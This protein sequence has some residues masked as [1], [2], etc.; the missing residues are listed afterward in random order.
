MRGGERAFRLRRR[1]PWHADHAGGGKGRHVPRGIHPRTSRP[2]TNATSPLFGVDFDHYHST[3]SQE[4]RELADADLH[5]LARRRQHRPPLDP[6]VVRPGSSRCSCPTATSRATARIAARADQYGDNCENCGAAYSPTDL[7]NPR[8]V[9]SG[10]TPELRDS[11]H[12]FFELGKFEAVPARMAVGR[13]RR[14]RGQGQAGRVAGEAACA[15]GIF[16]A[17]RPTSVSRFR[18][19]RASFSTSGW[20]R[21]SATWPA[22]EPTAR[23]TGT[24]FD[25]FLKPGQPGRDASFHRQGHHQFPRPVLAGDAA[26][27][28]LPHADQRC[29]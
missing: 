28:R 22:S 23:R 13:R 12:Y 27:R 8:S 25:A 3:H 17:T 7:K 29:T 20:M 18:T 9:V 1:R 26:R 11:E 15:T 21:R 24:D 10:A 19:R 6:A 4:N 14:F 5:P 16:R 2:A